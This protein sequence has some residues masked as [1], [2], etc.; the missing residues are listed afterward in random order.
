MNHYCNSKTTHTRLL[1][2]TG[3]GT[4]HVL[5]FIYSKYENSIDVECQYAA[6]MY[7]IASK[8][9]APPE[10]SGEK[11]AMYLIELILRANHF[12]RNSSIYPLRPAK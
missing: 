8:M 11:A 10:V 12:H 6:D 9:T 5:L 4:N 3:Q 7:F 2:Y 1:F